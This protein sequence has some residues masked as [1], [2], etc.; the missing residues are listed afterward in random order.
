M[1]ALKPEQSSGRHFGSRLIRTAAREVSQL[2][3]LERAG[4]SEWTP[5]IV[6]AG[7]IVFFVAI[8]LLTFGIVEGAA[9]LLASVCPQG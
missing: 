9:R 3:Q 5:W 2:H 1:N 6:I 8:G 7:L 4:E